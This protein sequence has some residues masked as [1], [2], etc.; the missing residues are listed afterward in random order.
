MTGLMQE[1]LRCLDA[2]LEVRT[3]GKTHRPEEIAKLNAAK[4][5]LRDLQT[6]YPA[7]WPMLK[8]R[9]GQCQVRSII[10]ESSRPHEKN[11]LSHEKLA[12]I[13]P[14]VSSSAI[15][16][17]AAMQDRAFPNLPQRRP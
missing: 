8:R 2:Q 6:T 1:M 13:Q 15:E 7:S 5:R 12:H 17:N 11:L 4:A 3:F 10:E 16:N 9:L 14:F